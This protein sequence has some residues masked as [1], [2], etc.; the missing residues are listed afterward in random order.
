MRAFVLTIAVL[1]GCGSDPCDPT[2]EAC[3]FESAVSTIDVPAGSEDENTCQ[4][5]TLNNPTELWVHSVTQ[6]NDGGYHHANWFFVPDDQFVLPDGAWPCAANNFE[7]LVAA[8]AGG[9]LFALSTQSLVETQTLPAGAA[10]RIPPYSRIIG[11][12]HLQNA[13]DFAIKSTMRL[14][15]DTV[16]PADVAAKLAPARIT[17]HDLHLDPDARSAFTTECLLDDQYAKWVQGP[18]HYTLYFVLVHYHSL[19]LYQQ[20][21]IAGGPR[22]GEVIMRHDGYGDNAG[23][24]IDPPLD[25]AA[26]GARGV[27]LTCGYQNPRSSVV[28]WGI[29]DQEMCVMALQAATEIGWDGLVAD[30]TG[31]K[32][33]VAPDGEVRYQ[34]ACGINSFP[35]DFTKEGGKGH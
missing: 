22:D 13:T 5:W 32:T 11:A 4:S 12:S 14:Q 34:G 3:T 30:G 17:Y 28:G 24:A 9:F 20:L 25:L 15:I 23:H 29:G 16:P 1:A 8:L 27:R 10:I 7:E 26:A 31:T 2:Q 33:G 18:F 21:E 19:G 35:W 6:R